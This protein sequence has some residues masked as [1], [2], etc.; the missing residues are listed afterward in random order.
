MSVFQPTQADVSAV[1]ALCMPTGYTLGYF[2]GMWNTEKNAKDGL[3]SLLAITPSQYNGAP[4]TGQVLYNHTGCG[5]AGSSCLEDIAEVF[6]QRAQELDSTGTLAGHLEY[7]WESLGAAASFTST[8]QNLFQGAEAIFADLQARVIAQIATSIASTVSNDPLTAA[9]YAA[10]NTQ[11]DALVS[12]GQ[13]LLLVAHSQGNLF[14]NH[15]YDHILPSVGTNRVVAVQIAPAS[16][17][18]RGSY[19]LANI[20]LVI[21]AL[22]I[23]GNSTVPA[24]NITLPVSVTDLTGHA[25]TGTYLDTARPARAQVVNLLN[26]GLASLAAPIFLPNV[27]EAFTVS[28]TWSGSG[29]QHIYVYEPDG[30]EVDYAARQGDTGYLNTSSPVGAGSEKYVVLCNASVM[31]TGTYRVAIGNTQDSDTMG[32]TTIVVAT[33]EAGVVSTLDLFVVP[34]L[35]YNTDLFTVYNILVSKDAATGIFSMSADRVP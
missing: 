35:P 14:L 3:K 16:P 22:R 27:I 25:L 26:S 8:I 2:N 18:L 24:N 30:T 17:T 12:K 15:A 6:E 7:F 10:Q 1:Q 4:V 5:Q 21:N 19:V 11:L 28:L 29:S 34:Q 32:V 33:P 9:D 23:Q 13:E 31:Q 20:D